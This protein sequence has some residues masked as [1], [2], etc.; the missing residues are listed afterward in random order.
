M[1]K[2]M[3]KSYRIL[4]LEASYIYKHEH[5]LGYGTE[6]GYKLP[7][8]GSFGYFSRFRNKLDYSLDA[9]ELER[10][11]EDICHEPFSFC[12]GYRNEYTLAVINVK[13]NY[14]YTPDKDEEEDG[15][16]TEKSTLD[17]GSVSTRALREIYY[18]DG[19]CVDGVR[20]VRYKRSAGSS[21]QGKCLFIDKRLCDAMNKWSDCGLEKSVDLASWESYRAL[22]L[23]SIKEPL[24]DIP[25]DRIL[26]VDDKPSEVVDDV[27]S[28]ELAE[29]KNKK[30]LVAVEKEYSVK[31]EIW[32][33]ES[34]LD[35]SMFEG[36]YKTRHMLLLRN[37]FFK[38]C[39]FK[40][41]LQKWIKDK[42]ITLDALKA[43][44]FITLATD[45][46]QIVMVT[47]PSSLKYLKFVGGLNEDN[48]RK[49]KA[50]VGSA[51]GV[52][53]WDKSTKY[54]GG[55]MVRASYQLLNTLG[56]TDEEVGDMMDKSINYLNLIRSDIDFMRHYF[57]FVC[58][59]ES[60]DVGD[61]CEF[62][63]EE[64]GRAKA[65]QELK[66]PGG[67]YQRADV[68]FR[69]MQINNDF[70]NTSLYADLCYHIVKSQKDALLKG[71][72]LLN[73][74]NATLFGNGPELLKYLAGEEI[75]STLAP[76]QIR[77]TKFEDKRK[78]L[79]ARSP[80]ITMGNLYCAENNLDGDI[81]GYF[82]LGDNI[83]CVNA[84]G[85]NLQQRLNGC[86]YDS[87]TMLITDDSVLVERAQEFSQYFKVPV[88]NIKSG[89]K[90]E[91][92]S[93]A[94]L[95]KLDYEMKS[96]KIGEIVNLSQKLNSIIWDKINKGG[97][98]ESI[99]KI[100][101][102]V[103]KLAVLSGLEIDK[104]KRA[105]EVNAASELSRIKKKYKSDPY[106]KFFK[107]I[108]ATSAK[109]HKGGKKGKNKAGKGKTKYRLYNT[110]ME[111]V[112]KIASK[113]DFRKEKAYRAEYKPVSN[114][115]KYEP[116][117]SVA[118]CEARDKIVN[119]CLDYKKKISDEFADLSNRTDEADVIFENVA[120]LR[121]ERDGKIRDL[122]TNEDILMLVIKYFDRRAD[123]EQKRSYKTDWYIY[124][125][126]LDNGLLK[127]IL[128]ESKEKLAE[129]HEDE[130]GQYDLYDFKYSKI[131]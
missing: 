2:N 89:D 23:S 80:H 20:Y 50:Q 27:I 46:D 39:C 95:V 3:A 16:T 75:T 37:K 62:G 28:I 124:G 60:D 125:P 109:K 57:T 119:I 59:R 111:H 34:L 131:Y 15:N 112:Y 126:L 38:S 56:L 121:A 41:K 6:V 77:C 61:D 81:W 97:D 25:I 10:I 123:E 74:T 85:E 12:D 42:G 88:C 83:V 31:N 79:C 115:F 100:Y 103:C 66:N 26:F 53:K 94:A 7:E 107:P 5:E 118:N 71:R 64:S 106:P 58:S 55:K 44:G 43:R 129:I 84:I 102:D 29:H 110:V 99:S 4:S 45:I 54:F 122:M 19:F 116:I 82:D 128:K 33:G 14:T 78:L 101:S 76:G 67:V 87:D 120:N 21:R 49:W 114:M 51:F 40:T 98:D 73:G 104:A 36:Y 9:I 22:S 17:S 72:V 32:D 47:T 52:V 68:I 1:R 113:I 91:D 130:F 63:D 30:E 96:N 13:F 35:E 69:L 8:R 24:I 86:D 48:I 11:Y 127:N 105:F 92:F 90:G 18:R 117:E 65:E 93:T 70:Q 108:R